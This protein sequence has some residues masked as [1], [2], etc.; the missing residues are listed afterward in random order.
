MH[1]DKFNASGSRSQ[2][3]ER[4]ARGSQR[5]DVKKHSV[6]D[7][8]PQQRAVMNRLVSRGDMTAEEYIDSL[9][10]IGEL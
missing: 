3:V 5:R 8:N 6:R 4:P 10:Q 7:L 9:V 1:R 2:E